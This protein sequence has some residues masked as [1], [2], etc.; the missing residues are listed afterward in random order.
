FFSSLFEMAGVNNVLESV[1]EDDFVEYFLFPPIETCDEKEQETILSSILSE[2][3][4]IV[5]KYT[6]NYLWHKDEFKLIPRTSIYN[7][8]SHIDGKRETLAPHLYGVSHYGDN[9]E[10]EWFMVYLCDGNIHLIPLDALEE[11]STIGVM[12]SLSKIREQPLETLASADVQNSLKNKLKGYPEKSKDNLHRSAIY[13]PMGIAMILKEKP[14]LI[15]PAVQAF[16]NRDSVDMKAC[17]AMKYFPPENRVMTSVTFTKCLYAMLMHSN[18]LPDRRTGWN[19]PPPN[20]SQYKAHSL[21]V[22][23][24]CGFEILISHAKPSADI[25]TDRSWH[26]YLK[27]LQDKGYFK[28]LLEHSIDYNNLLNKAKEY[29]INHRDSM[30]CSPAIGQEILELTKLLDCNVDDSKTRNIVCLKM[31]MIPG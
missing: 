24:A 15:A 21:G 6:D 9:I 2:V 8:L 31:M 3:N 27:T 25:E 7:T 16:C 12:E 1:R 23:V 20:T 14:N 28:G 17:R 11:D 30:Q 19:L 4:K 5:K 22:K 10:D 18:Y 29:Y 13:V 26:S